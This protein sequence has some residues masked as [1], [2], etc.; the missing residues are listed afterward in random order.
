MRALTLTSSQPPR[1]EARG[2]RL[3]VM[4]EAALPPRPKDRGFRAEF[5]MTLTYWVLIYRTLARK[6]RTLVRG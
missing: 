5:A 2:F 1:A 4:K 6:P 3:T